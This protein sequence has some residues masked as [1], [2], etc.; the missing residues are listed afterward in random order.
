MTWEMTEPLTKVWVHG[1]EVE[2]VT[3]GSGKPLLLL[4]SEDG[5]ESSAAAIDELAKAFAVTCVSHP[6]FGASALPRYF[7]T[8]DDLAYFYLD[9]M[10]HFDLQ[11]AVVVGAGIGGWIAAEVATK[12]IERLSHLVLVNSVGVKF[13]GREAR[14]IADIYSLPAA[15]VALRSYVNPASVSERGASASEDA[16][17]RIVRNRE[18]T[19]LFGWSPYMHNPKLRDRLH[20]I[21]VPCLVLWG[22]DDGITP[23]S[24]GEAY[25]ARLPNARFEVIADAAHHVL[26]EQPQSACRNI[27]AFAAH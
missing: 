4:H 19:A 26:Y 11:E 16:L 15:E 1:I 13:G 24:Y 20:R 8:I 9:L 22:R 5:I 17:T 25:A 12:S 2:L 27:I 23:L 21:V 10:D 6:G 3:K 14:E 18:A 7:S